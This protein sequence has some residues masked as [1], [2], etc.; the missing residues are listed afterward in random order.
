MGSVLVTG[1]TGFIGS[2]LV[3]ELEQDNEVYGLSRRP[4]SNPA[5]ILG[6]I[7]D[8]SLSVGDKEFD[9]IFHLASL[10]PLEKNSTKLRQTNKDGV[11]NLMSAIRDRTKSLVYVSGLGV[12]GAAR[13]VV[14][15]STPYNPD[16]SFARMRLEA[17]QYMEKECR[18]AG[19]RFTTV[20]FGDVYGPGGWFQKLVVERMRNGLFMIPGGGGNRKAFLTV[21]DAAGS[22]AA[23]H[24]ANLPHPKYVVADPEV[25]TLRDFFEYTAHT[26]GV[27]K[28]KSVPAFAARLKLGGDLVKLLCTP[29][30]VSNRLI[31]EIYQFKCPGYQAGIVAAISDMQAH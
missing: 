15:E 14:N 7:Q 30:S 31:S 22:L 2:S 13:G 17:Q 19:I 20:Y 28:P 5:N 24:R 12:F 11:R 23:V 4:D 8:A 3:R 27:K 6:D 18:D 29:V 9:C 21:G 25:V 10:T 26:L 16:T 1:S